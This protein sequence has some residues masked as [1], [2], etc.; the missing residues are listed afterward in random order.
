MKTLLVAI[1]LVSGSAMAHGPVSQQAVEAAKVAVTQF[2]KVQPHEVR[3]EF[4][5]MTAEVTGHERVSVELRVKNGQAYRYDC[6][7]NE[8]VKPVVW[9]CQTLN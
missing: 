9:E 4:R 7:E 1:V 2:N 5:S 3:K 8:D 6:H